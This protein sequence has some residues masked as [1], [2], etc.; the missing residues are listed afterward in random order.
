MNKMINFGGQPHKI[1]PL[2]R[3]A[4]MAMMDADALPFDGRIEMIEGVLIEMS[5]SKHRHARAH[6][7]MILGIGRNVPDRFELVTEPALYLTDEL[8]LN[9]DLALLPKGVLC[10]N[11][12]GSDV[13]LL[14]EIADSTLTRDLTEK[15]R[16]YGQS[17]V[18]EY[19]VVDLPNRKLHIYR[20]PKADGYGSVVS[21]EWNISVSALCVPEVVLTLEDILK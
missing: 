17:G 8:M 16:Y 18:C 13:A 7:Q 6:T 3:A 4:I 19:W 14:V 5:P 9:P 20:E 2:N 21:Q 15:A 11:A 10:Q 1:A 12:K